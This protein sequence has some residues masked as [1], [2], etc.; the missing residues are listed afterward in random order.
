[1][2]FYDD[3]LGICLFYDAR[4]CY[5]V[6]D[7]LPITDPNRKLEA[8]KDIVV[9]TEQISSL[10]KTHFPVENVI[11]PK[12]SDK[13]L[14]AELLALKNYSSLPSSTKDINS[15]E[16]NLPFSSKHTTPNS[17]GIKPGDMRFEIS[18]AIDLN[19]SDTCPASAV[20]LESSGLKDVQQRN[21]HIRLSSDR[22]R[23]SSECW[24]G[25][26]TDS[27]TTTEEELAVNFQPKPKAVNGHIGQSAEIAAGR[28]LNFLVSKDSL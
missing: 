1:M 26:E 25:I 8:K 14:L 13:K 3:C 20:M 6:A 16:E 17:Q 22:L 11:F 12:E 27:S 19:A 4:Y 10:N 18:H 2:S 15:S 9:I 5:F 24:D 7:V 21:R 28:Q 23:R